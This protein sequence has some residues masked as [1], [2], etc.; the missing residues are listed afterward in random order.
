[1]K[2]KLRESL[3]KE[4]L[5]EEV[6]RYVSKNNEPL[7]EMVFL[8]GDIYKTS[9]DK[10]TKTKLNEVFNILNKELKLD[11]DYKLQDLFESEEE[12]CVCE[13]GKKICTYCE[14]NKKEVVESK[15]KVLKK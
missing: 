14:K 11:E 6:E 1:M 9:K 10:N 15:K 3:F 8:L 2:I 4:I 7:T 13:D 5:K 12:T